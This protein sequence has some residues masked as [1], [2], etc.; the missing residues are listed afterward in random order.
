MTKGIGSHTK[1]AVAPAPNIQTQA[2]I[3]WRYYGSTMRFWCFGMRVVGVRDTATMRGYVRWRCLG[4]WRRRGGQKEI[5]GGASVEKHRNWRARMA[6]GLAR[7]GHPK[8]RAGELVEP[9]P[10][11]LYT[12]PASP[13]PTP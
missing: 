8:F 1:K 9:Q 13:P 5:C 6:G 10:R 7:T 2:D 11:H 3:F 4:G 12:T